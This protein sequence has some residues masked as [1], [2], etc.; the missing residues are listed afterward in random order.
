[1]KDLRELDDRYLPRAAAKVAALADS[2]AERRERV[3][4]RFRSVDPHA[5]R[6]VDAGTLR[7]LDARYASRGPL[8]LL[9][10]VPQVGFVLIG[11]VFLAG[12]GTAVSREGA[13]D[14]QRVEVVIPGAEGEDNG[15][16]TLGPEAGEVVQTYFA[17]AKEGLAAVAKTSSSRVALVSLRGYLTPGQVKE[18]LSGYRVQRIYLR[19]RAGG[20]DAA[21]LSIDIIGNLAS[22]LPKAYAQAAHG[23]DLARQSYQGYVDTLTVSTSEDQAFKDL[24]AAFATSTA[25]EANDYRG[26]CPCVYAVVVS[27]TPRQLNELA[28]KQA[29]RGVEVAGKGLMLG[30]LQV[31]PL[32]PEVTDVV[33]EQQAADQPP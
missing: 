3:R 12:A 15:S 29:V 22:A 9:R 21:Q 6:H 14:K 10:D 20:K 19:S 28:R 25:A 11:L 8:A 32:L 30:Q 4:R 23:R 1:M 27:A 26:S 16:R 18:L 17:D 5:L 33:P 2:L 7:N 24:Y 13:K 31:L